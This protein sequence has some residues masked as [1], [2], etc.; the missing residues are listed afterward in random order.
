MV[1]IASSIDNL[2]GISVVYYPT[3]NIALL[4]KTLEK[5]HVGFSHFTVDLSREPRW[6]YGSLTSPDPNIRKSAIEHIKDCI[7]ATVKI[8]ASLINLCPMGDGYDYLFQADY[9]KAWSWLIEGLKE[10]CSYN[11]NIRI[12]IEYKRKE[13]RG[14]IYVS[15]I[16]KAL[17]ICERVKAEN[18]GITVDF[19]HS[20]LSGENPA[21]SICIAAEANKLFSIHLNDNFGDWDWD[22]IPASVNFWHFIETIIWMIKVEYKGWIYMDVYPFR[23]DAIKAISQSISNVKTLI[24]ILQKI[25]LDTLQAE[26]RDHNYVRALKIILKE[27]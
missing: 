11:P 17:Y 2:D 6:L 12:S 21:E 22:M 9:R 8:N 23:V 3:T 16:G 24:E 7:D 25:D 5:Y 15:D 1:K 13:P 20:L 4:K 26:L 19:G 14:N 27:I 10:V 18:L